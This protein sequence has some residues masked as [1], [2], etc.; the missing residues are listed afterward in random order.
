MNAKYKKSLKIATLLISAIIIAT[1]SATTY[2]YM[3]IHGSATIS[4][5][6][7]S[8]TLGSSAPSGAQ[9]NGHTVDNMNFSVP[10]D[11]FQNFTDALRLVNS[12][13]SNGYS[14]DLSTDVTAGNTTKFSTF[15]MVVYDSTGAPLDNLDVLTEEATSSS[16]TI[17][18]DETLYVRFEIE[19]LTGE[20]SGYL[21]FT[22]QLTY[23][24]P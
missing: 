18:A 2:S 17:D 3:F 20:T 15:N 16:L 6:I 12:D 8:W 9:I 19:P 23:T 21:A 11:T 4:S 7:L 22:V 10:Q 13:V 5:G 24:I 14:F 1:A